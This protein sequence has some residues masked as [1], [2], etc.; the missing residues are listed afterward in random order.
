[1]TKDVIISIKGLQFENSNDELAEPV[2]VIN[3]GEYYNK[4]GKHYIMFDEV[5]EGFTES[6]KNTL[7]ISDDKVDIT[8]KGITNVH[9][10]FEENKKNV[11]CYNT[12]YGSIMIGIDAREINIEEKEESINVKVNYGLEVNYEHLANCSITINV[13]AKDSNG[14]SL[15]N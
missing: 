8:K 13:M 14:F 12:P 9:M 7:K 1:M 5:V 6:T 10:A 15:M 3:F 2:E 11:T 4:N